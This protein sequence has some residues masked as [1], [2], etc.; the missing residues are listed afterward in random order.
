VQIYRTGDK[1]RLL[2]QGFFH[3]RA[4]LGELHFLK[5]NFV[6]TEYKRSGV[7]TVT[8]N[9]SKKLVALGHDVTVFARTQAQPPEPWFVPINPP[10]P[11]KN[12]ISYPIYAAK[13][14][15]GAN[16]DVWH[17][18]VVEMGF[19][20]K[21]AGKKPLVASLHDAV[22]L[23]AP[24][25]SERNRIFRLA[26]RLWV[27]Q[28][29]KYAQ[30]LVFD[31]KSALSDAVATG[32][33]EEKCFF[34]YDGVDTKKFY[35]NPEKNRSR[36][37]Q[38]ETPVLSYAG[39][40]GKRKRLDRLAEALGILRKQGVDFKLR[41]AGNA[42]AQVR[43]MFSK[44]GVRNVEFAGYVPDEKMRRFYADSDVFVFPSDYEGFGLPV[45]EAMACGVPVVAINRSSIPEVI[46]NAGVLCEPSA[47]DF[48]GAI[49]GIL[50]DAK[51]RNALS[52]KG[53]LRAREFSWD[54]TTRGFLKIYSK[55]MVD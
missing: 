11:F 3:S 37:K 14:I 51:K 33:P 1:K 26:Y 15:A 25:K 24:Y 2:P 53:V 38:R 21:L 16:A 20:C 5:I 36:A 19:A 44:R 7:G 41:V 30:A 22:P 9:V 27:S 52:K 12:N 23:I 49:A 17:G 31:S 47:E 45:L 28:V 35:P 13:K 54:K 43:G 4:R 10:A 46:G 55:A 48:A 18:D 32:L 50:A 40:F 6:S 42:D 34:V 39:G 8:Y 29:S